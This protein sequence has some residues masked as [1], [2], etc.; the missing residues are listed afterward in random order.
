VHQSGYRTYG[1]GRGGAK[2]ERYGPP[3]LLVP[4]VTLAEC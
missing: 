1:G 3:Y 2:A 4:C